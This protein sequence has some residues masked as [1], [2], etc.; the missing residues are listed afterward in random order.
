[1]TNHVDGYVDKDEINLTYN[2]EIDYHVITYS[3]KV[4]GAVQ[5]IAAK[6]LEEVLSKDA[7]LSLGL[8]T[9]ALEHNA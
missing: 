6:D 4:I 7:V 5:S 3:L 9:Y 8:A 2:H 1:M